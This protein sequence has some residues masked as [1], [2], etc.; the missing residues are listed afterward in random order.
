MHKIQIYHDLFFR[1]WSDWV[2]C[3]HRKL[4]M[5][6]WLM[7]STLC[8][9]IIFLL[10]LWYALFFKLIQSVRAVHPRNL[11][12]LQAVPHIRNAVKNGLVLDSRFL[13]LKMDDSFNFFVIYREISTSD[14][15]IGVSIVINW[16]WKIFMLHIYLVNS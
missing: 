12:V 9:G 11:T 6:R 15:E 2:S 4:N 5:P 3:L 13:F 8:L 16:F 7:T 1:K 14:F 10:W